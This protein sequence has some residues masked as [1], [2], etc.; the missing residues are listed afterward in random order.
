MD[1][2]FDLEQVPPGDYLIAATNPGYL[3]PGT[4]KAMDFNATEDELKKFID[5]LPSVHVTV[6]QTSRVDLSLHRG[7]VISGRMQYPDGS[8]AIAM[9][10]QCEPAN[11]VALTP[12]IA[13]KP[14]GP[15]LAALMSLTS[16]FERRQ[17]AT[18]D[19]GRF[20][21]SGLPPGKYLVGT[22]ISLDHRPAFVGMSDGGAAPSSTRQPMYPEMIPVY[23][24]GV[25]RRSD[26]RVFDIHEDE[27]ITD[28][29]LTIDPGGLHTITGVIVAGPDHHNPNGVIVQFREDG[30]K[31]IARFVEAL[32]DGS[33]QINF[34]PSGKYTLI[35]NAND[36]RDPSMEGPMVVRSY[37]TLKLPVIVGTDNIAL[38]DVILTPLK[39]G[40]KVDDIE[41]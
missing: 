23:S 5:S 18:D 35:V 30:V 29:D 25:F 27:Q 2:N 7:A 9:L 31:Q 41:F 40:E 10:L 28:A 6:N 12:A 3:T 1:G 34:L 32:S 36:L 13:H 17:N 33:F 15:R 4:T 20:R 14:V 22:I 11:N 19:Q 26:G 39:P 16:A 24:P 37:K 21:I 8:P 38:G